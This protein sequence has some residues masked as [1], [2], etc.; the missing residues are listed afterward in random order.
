[1]DSIPVK[2]SAPKPENILHFFLRDFWAIQKE[3][4]S[5]SVQPSTVLIGQRTSMVYQFTGSKF[6]NVQIVF[7]PSAVFR[8]TGI[9]AYELTNQHLDA[10]LIFGNSI[11]RTLDQ[12]QHA[13]SYNEL[14]TIIEAFAFTLVR[15]ARKDR[16][17]LDIMSHQMIRQG[18]DVSLDALADG[19]CL[20]TKQFQRKFNERIG[21][22]PK[23]YARIIRLTR[24]Y[25]LRNAHP[26]KDWLEIA[27][28]CGYYD[29]QHLVKDYKDFT[30]VTPHTFLAM[31]GQTPERV[32]GL[33][34]RLYKDRVKYIGD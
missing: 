22:N 16:L 3:G 5:K 26:D 20:G 7:Q 32:L 11:Q 27:V 25:N 19:A 31:E 24:A 12:L 6:L 30:G 28:M 15:T 2:P 33:T 17:S 18:G 8:L 1:M 34:D 4:E 9:P 29:Y 14:L 21:V 10:T 23:T 13:E